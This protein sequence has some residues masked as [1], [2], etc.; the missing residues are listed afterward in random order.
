M[1]VGGVR[2]RVGECESGSVRVHDSESVSTGMRVGERV[3][4]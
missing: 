4:A 1:R 2:V 3:C